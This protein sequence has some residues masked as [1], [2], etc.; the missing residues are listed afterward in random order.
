MLTQG[1]YVH[2]DHDTVR[3]EIRDQPGLQVPL[4]HLEG[5][6]VF[7]NVLLSP[8]L[9]HRF[10][11]EGKAIVWFD[12]HGRFEGRLVGPTSGNVLLRKAQYEMLDEPGKLLYLARQFVSG[13]I[14]NSRTVLQRA[15]RE[16]PARAVELGEA[17]KTLGQALREL[18]RA[19]TL[20]EVRGIEG[21]SAATYFA[22]LSAMI[23]P[24]TGFHFEKR[25]RRPPRDPVNSL[26]SFAYAL[27]TN[28]C[29]AALEGVG[30][31]PQVGYL[32][33]LR[34]G[35]PALA[36]D[37]VE[38]L[39]PILADRLALT[40]INRMQVTQEDFVVRPG[41]AVVLTD[42]GRRKFLAAYQKRRREEVTHPMLRQQ[43][44]LGLV[45]HVQARLL[46]RYVRGDAASYLPFLVR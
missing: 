3:V 41:G 40:L 46:A 10:A 25:I 6:V 17:V 38:E 32:H 16:S 1:A 30:L 27:L 37:L 21:Q 12:E 2:L 5:L 20:D 36:L 7:G 23:R 45:P 15:A 11:G 43:V 18:E 8:F 33:T 4:H 29:S 13:K 42:A 9:I 39:R 26:L 14:R 22:A 19:T 28:D 24:E 44:P 34:P 31:D 35:R